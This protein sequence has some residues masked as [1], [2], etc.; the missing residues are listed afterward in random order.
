MIFSCE[1]PECVVFNELTTVELLVVAMVGMMFLS[2]I[3]L[4]GVEELLLALGVF[5][6]TRKSAS[7]IVIRVTSYPSCAI[8]IA[9]YFDSSLLVRIS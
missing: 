7:G 6:A 8:Q 4:R 9:C 3:R 5:S 2:P 1:P